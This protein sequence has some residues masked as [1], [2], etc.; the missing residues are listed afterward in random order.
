MSCSDAS[1]K[2]SITRRIQYLRRRHVEANSD[3]KRILQGMADIA[4]ERERAEEALAEDKARKPKK[5][6][7]NL[8]KPAIDYRFES[9]S[10]S[11]QRAHCSELFDDELKFYVGMTVW[12][13]ENLYPNLME[14]CLHGK[15]Y[16]GDCY[17]VLNVSSTIK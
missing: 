7:E 12:E 4:K 15:F 13:I 16:E 10:C 6:N 5:W 9:L 8:N 17:I 11:L 2:D 3:E 14:D 1:N